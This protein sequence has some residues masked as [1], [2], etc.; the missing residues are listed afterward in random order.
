MDEQL[1]IAIRSIQ[2][3]TD[4]PEVMDK[5]TT[6]EAPASDPDDRDPYDFRQL[7]EDLEKKSD[8]SVGRHD[9]PDSNQGE[10]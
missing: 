8:V 2:P 4:L 10:Q 3:R 6:L 5:P 1:Q 9:D 7:E